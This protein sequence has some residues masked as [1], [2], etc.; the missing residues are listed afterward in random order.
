MLSTQ[1]GLHKAAAVYNKEF[2]KTY[3]PPLLSCTQIWIRSDA[4]CFSDR[5]LFSFQNVHFGITINGMASNIS[6]K[7]I[8]I[9]C[10]SEALFFLLKLLFGICYI[11]A[12]TCTQLSRMINEK[13]SVQTSNN[14]AYTYGDL[15][16]RI[17]TAGL[18]YTNVLHKFYLIYQISGVK[19]VTLSVCCVILFISISSAKLKVM[20]EGRVTQNVHWVP[21]QPLV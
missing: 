20:S 12:H 11:H 15:G 7:Y 8:Y 18:V 9:I 21:Q 17:F 2:L 3:K 19:L 13:L 14:P 16:C 1:C 6:V 5:L 4:S 10:L